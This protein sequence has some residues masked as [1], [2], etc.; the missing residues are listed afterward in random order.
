M[1][2]RKIEIYHDRDRRQV[3][4]FKTFH[5]SRLKNFKENTNRFID[6]IRYLSSLCLRDLIKRFNES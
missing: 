5:M 3:I 1:L 4:A 6:L 2:K